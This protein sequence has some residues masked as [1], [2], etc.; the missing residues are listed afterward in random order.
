LSD[1]NQS[2]RTLTVEFLFTNEIYAD[3]ARR[4]Y[5]DVLKKS[6]LYRLT[7]MNG[8]IGVNVKANP[9]ESQLASQKPTT[10]QIQPSPYSDEGNV[11]LKTDRGFISLPDLIKAIDECRYQHTMDVI[12]NLVKKGAT[13]SQ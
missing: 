13:D 8:L 11:L 2:N 3:I 6:G 5:F 10:P 7:C 12:R 1:T 4:E 9:K